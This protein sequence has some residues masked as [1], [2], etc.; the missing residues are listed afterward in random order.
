VDEAGADSKLLA[1]RASF[2]D[3]VASGSVVKM[4]TLEPLVDENVQLGFDGSKGR[5]EFFS[6]LKSEK[7]KDAFLTT[8]RLGGHFQNLDGQRFFI[9][10]FSFTE[11]TG[12]KYTE[13]YV[14]ALQRPLPVYVEGRFGA[15]VRTHV[16][17][18]PIPL[19]PEERIHGREFIPVVIGGSEGFVH[20]ST[21]RSPLDYRVMFVK[22]VGGWKLYLF[23]AGN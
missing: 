15:K 3:L 10:P 13:H 22:T 21:V 9:A 19:D 6:L 1:V 23:L 20:R 4:K 7:V 8:L 14:V 18:G 11:R 5:N 2:I 16:G 12:V 17:C